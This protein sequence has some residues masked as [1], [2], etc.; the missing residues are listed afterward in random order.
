MKNRSI[1]IRAYDMATDLR[2]LSG[3]WLAASRHAHAFIGEKRLLEQQNLIEEQYLP[4][5]ETWVACMKGEAVGFI[6]LMDTFIGGLFV[7]PLVHGSGV[8]RALVAHALA[9]KGNLSLEVYTAN[10]GAMAF[11]EKLGFQIQSRREIDDQ[12]LPF[13]N[14]RMS[15]TA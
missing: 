9:L 11:Y 13:A 5:A 12:G 6:S 2:T 10:V 14:A 15:L 4:A 1:S 3:I 7:D 8:G